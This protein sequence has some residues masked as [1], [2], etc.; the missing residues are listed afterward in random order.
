MPVFLHIGCGPKRK[1]PSTP[2]FDTPDWDE[3]RVDI[4]PAGEPDILADMT[5]LSAIPSESVDA[6][7]SSHNLEHIDFHLVPRALGEFR[8]VLRPSG[9]VVVTCPDLQ[10]VA[11]LVAEGRLNEP[12]YES[13]AGPISAL[14]II[15]GHQAAIAKGKTYMAH[16]CGFTL[17][18]L[19]DALIGAGFGTATAA[20]RRSHL[21][22]W[23]VA[24]KA[25]QPEAAIQALAQ[26]HFPPLSPAPSPP[27]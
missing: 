5:D 2:G 11:G 6:V 20:R 18:S 25:A 8:R 21:E 4:S 15:Y 19:F 7:F 16:R 27:G 23:A 3:L 17:K 26:R 1:G 22:L 10:M 24:S 9:F 12:I 14:D 13:P